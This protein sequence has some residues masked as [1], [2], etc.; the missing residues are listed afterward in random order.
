MEQTRQALRFS[1]SSHPLGLLHR[2]T[3]NCYKLRDKAEVQS[4]EARPKAQT[5][6]QQL[7]Q[8]EGAAAG[9]Q[10]LET[11]AELLLAALAEASRNQAGT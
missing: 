8:D 7:P 11:G 3:F 6:Q 2:I 1:P 4:E 10:E 5:I 9:L